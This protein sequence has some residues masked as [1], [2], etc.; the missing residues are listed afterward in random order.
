ML[1]TSCFSYVERLR[2]ID[3]FV[4][5]DIER[6][7]I[8]QVSMRCIIVLANLKTVTFD[9][10][11]VNRAQPLLACKPSIALS[12]LKA[13]LINARCEKACGVLPNCS[14]VAAISS[15]NMPR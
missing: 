13:A 10:L 1:D 7:V 8:A 14:P 9:L 12:R 3:R 5:A 2:I 4:R 15:E 6:T 11:D